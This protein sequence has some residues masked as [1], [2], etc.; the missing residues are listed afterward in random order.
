MQGTSV[1][2]SKTTEKIALVKEKEGKS[3]VRSYAHVIASEMIK[4]LVKLGTKTGP[5][6][7]SS[8]PCPQDY[9]FLLVHVCTAVRSAKSV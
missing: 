1:R 6:L 5:Q 3:V 7:H 8:P 9:F 2:N 4:E